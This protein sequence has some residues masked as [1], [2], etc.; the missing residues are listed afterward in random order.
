MV[1]VVVVAVAV[2]VGALVLADRVVMVREGSGMVAVVT[3]REG[4]GTV[5]VA[6]AVGA[7]VMAEGLGTLGDAGGTEV[8]T[9]GQAA[10]VVVPVVR[11]KRMLMKAARRWP[12]CLCCR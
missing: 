8:E 10:A 6:V 4:L 5:A 9:P 7:M 1:A 3:A 11:G 12:G 2:E